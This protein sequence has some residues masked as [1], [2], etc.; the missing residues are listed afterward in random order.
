MKPHEHYHRAERLLY[1]ADQAG[2]DWAKAHHLRRAAQVHATLALV[3][4]D[5]AADAE[6]IPPFTDLDVD[7]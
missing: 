5:V 3:R 7:V 6:R 1:A 4:R 2:E